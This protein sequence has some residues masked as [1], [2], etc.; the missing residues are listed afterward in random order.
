MGAGLLNFTI[1]II[2]IPIQIDAFAFGPHKGN[3]FFAP[4]IENEKFQ[5]GA[6]LWGTPKNKFCKP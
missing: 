5:G 1:K 2:L 4:Q 6:K 3:G